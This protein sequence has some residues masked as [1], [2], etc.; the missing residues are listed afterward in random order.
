MCPDFKKSMR[1]VSEKWSAEAEL[2]SV[3]LLLTPATKLLEGLPSSILQPDNL[4][5]SGYTQLSERMEL[6]RNRPSRKGTAKC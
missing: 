1:C 6:G 2:L 3:E 4:G 5:P